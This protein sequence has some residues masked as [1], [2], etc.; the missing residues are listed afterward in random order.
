MSLS[1]SQ[2]ST[3][4]AG[5]RSDRKER[6]V[7]S[8]SPTPSGPFDGAFHDSGTQTPPTIVYYPPLF[9]P[10]PQRVRASPRSA[11]TARPALGYVPQTP[12]LSPH[13]H[14]RVEYAGHGGQVVGKATPRT[15]GGGARQ[16]PR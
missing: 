9:K 10:A 2:A 6:A 11:Q 7:L 12:L 1:L 8:A 15:A 16:R 14:E 4:A 3:P 13:L 5:F